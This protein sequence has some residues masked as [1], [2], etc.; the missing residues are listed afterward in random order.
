MSIRL[1]VYI[2]SGKEVP[3]IPL[4]LINNK[5]VLDFRAKAELFQ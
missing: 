3:V 1:Y 5:L 4:L 2:A